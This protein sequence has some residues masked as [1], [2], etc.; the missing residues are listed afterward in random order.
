MGN[1]FADF[2]NLTKKPANM[3]VAMDV[4]GNAFVHLFMERMK[5]LCRTLAD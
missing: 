3:R 5:S 4:D 1:T 2:F